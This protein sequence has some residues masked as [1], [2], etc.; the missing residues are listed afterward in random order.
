MASARDYLPTRARLIEKGVQIGANC[1]WCNE[2]AE[3]TTHV[4]LQC[5]KSRETWRNLGMQ[6]NIDQVQLQNGNIEG[7]IFSILSNLSNNEKCTFV[8]NL[9]SLWRSRNV[10]VWDNQLDRTVDIIHRGSCLLTE[11]RIARNVEEQDLLYN[12]HRQGSNKWQR[13]PHNFIKCNVDA[14]FSEHHNKVGIG[15]C[16]R[17][18]FGMFMGARTLWY[19]PVTTV[20]IGEVLRLLAAIDWV[21]ELTFE[22]VIFC[23]DS[24]EVADSLYSDERDATELGSILTRCRDDLSNFC[25]NSYVEFSRREANMVAHNLAKAAIYNADSHI[26]FDIP[27]VLIL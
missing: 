27:I 15:I 24:K 11:W 12:H 13:P 16:L 23:E 26:Y 18:E 3:T 9:W 22:N 4:L 8:V 10:A 20:A 5:I 21:K 19:Q 2:E 17:D 14:S 7:I 1:L 6:Y 25:N